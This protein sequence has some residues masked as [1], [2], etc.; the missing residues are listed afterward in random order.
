MKHSILWFFLLACLI[1]NSAKA[2]VILVERGSSSFTYSN[3]KAAVDALQDDDKLYLPPGIISLEGYSWSGE[4]GN[5]NYTNSLAIT[6]KVAIYG[7]GYNQG[8]NSTI[9]QNGNLYFSAT[10]SGS[11]ITGVRF[12]AYFNLLNADNVSISRCKFNSTFATQEISQN[13]YINECEFKLYVSISDESSA[14]FTKCIFNYQSNN[15]FYNSTLTNNLFT[16]TS[17]YS[18][19]NSSLINN[20]FVGSKTTNSAHMPSGSNNSFS[21]N[22]WI[23]TILQYNASLNNTFS[24]EIEQVPFADTFMDFDKGDYRLKDT[25]SGK[26]AANDGHDVGI[27]GTAFPFKTSRLPSIPY[28]SIKAISAETDASG[29]LPVSLKIEAQER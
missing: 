18:F 20:I 14:V 7:A 27:F 22:M 10:A 11:T 26:G 29:N 8:A 19:Q 21:Y 6:K 28:F 4:T 15:S 1:G 25:S 2:Q 16:T 17:G 9:L 12:D 23:G 3:I 24:N 5:H 13:N